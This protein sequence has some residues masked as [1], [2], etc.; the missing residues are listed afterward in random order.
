MPPHAI[1]DNRVA[2][3]TESPQ[4]ASSHPQL[5]LRAAKAE[6]DVTV[7][8]GD[9]PATPTGGFAG[10]EEVARVGRRAM[11]AFN[12]LPAFAQDV[13]ILIDG[14]REGRSVE[15]QLQAVL[16][17]GG[18]VVFTA[19]GPIH[20][21]GGRFVFG[22]EPEFTEQVRAEGTTALI[23]V[24]MV[25]KLTEYVPAAVVGEK[26]KPHVAL[27]EAIPLEY[28]VRQGDTLVN[29]AGRLYPGEA[30]RWKQIGEKNGISDPHK[31]LKPGM[32]LIL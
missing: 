3:K 27:G 23:R 4:L 24:R 14:Y 21:S 31:K 8:M 28:T 26:K 15:R 1:A 7:D 2:P 25:L 12:G 20:R 32:E 11:T 6:V 17:L 13:P 5:R 18:A 30:A 29:I 9:G 19:V 22:D 10:W 16:A